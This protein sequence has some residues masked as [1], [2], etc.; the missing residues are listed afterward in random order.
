LTQFGTFIYLFLNKLITQFQSDSFLEI[1]FSAVILF[2][3]I[4]KL[5]YFVRIYQ[6]CNEIILIVQNICNEIVPFA[7]LSIALLFSLSKIYQVLHM[8]VNDP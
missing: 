2:L 5:M 6:P 4:Y 3:S 8:G 7:I 1:L